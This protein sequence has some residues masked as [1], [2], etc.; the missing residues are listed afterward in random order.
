M[1][2]N[3]NNIRKS[4]TILIIGLFMVS[5]SSIFIRLANVSPLI[6][7]FWRL[8]FSFIGMLLLAKFFNQTK[9]F[10]GIPRSYYKF[11][12]LSGFFL[13]LHFASW[14]LSLD[15]ISVTA[16]VTIVDSAPLFV[17]IGGF[18]FLKERINKFQV[19][20]II[21]SIIGGFIIGLSS[22]SI[23]T[24]EQFDPM[25]GN[26]LALIGAITVSGYLLIGRSVRQEIGIYAYMSWVYGFC[27]LFLLVI[28]LIFNPKEL[29][30]S[31]VFNIEI[32]N[33]V[34]FLLLAIGPSIMGHTFYNYAIKEVKA[35]IVSIVMLGEPIITSIL[36][37]LFLR[38]IPPSLVILGAAFVL[39]GVGL[40]IWKEGK[41]KPSTECFS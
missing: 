19:L 34:L 16:S 18:F 27:S 1:I 4:Y 3:L 13:A 23:N 15:Y 20:G 11:F 22:E 10:R 8:F 21:I 12:A 35:A 2:P 37:I 25:L 30:D 41:E 33:Y 40:T 26:T 6:T 28:A 32:Q 7:A 24:V 5:W 29:L 38:E 17:V 39:L 36:A 31:F 9:E 14:F